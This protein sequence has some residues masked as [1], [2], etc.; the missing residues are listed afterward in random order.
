[1]IHT[2]PANKCTCD[3][4][5]LHFIKMGNSCKLHQYTKIYI[6]ETLSSIKCHNIRQF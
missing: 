1:M 6:Y 5:H 3:D 2:A 4:V